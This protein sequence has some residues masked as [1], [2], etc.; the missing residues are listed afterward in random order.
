MLLLE[1]KTLVTIKKSDQSSDR[2]TSLSKQNHTSGWILDF[3]GDNI[4]E[5]VTYQEFGR[6]E[7][8]IEKSTMNL[9]LNSLICAKDAKSA[10]FREC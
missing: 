5:Y 7:V 1:N 9:Y 4:V 8:L 6:S 2:G 3:G 10:D